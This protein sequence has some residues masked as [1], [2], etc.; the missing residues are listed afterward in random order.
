MVVSCPTDAQYSLSTPV[1][2]Q[3]RPQKEHR[4]NEELGTEWG[5]RVR[6]RTLTG[7]PALHRFAKSLQGTSSDSSTRAASAL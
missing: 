7:N 2:Q 5:N 4:S 6:V 1:S 3:L